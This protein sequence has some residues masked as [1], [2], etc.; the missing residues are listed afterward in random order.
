MPEKINRA[1]EDGFASRKFIVTLFG[2]VCATGLAAIGK[3]DANVALVLTG[4]I[5]AYNW[6]NVRH[7]QS[8]A[9][10]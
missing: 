6:A 1:G 7:H 4:G 10:R 5:G 9:D 8:E 2:M 3:V